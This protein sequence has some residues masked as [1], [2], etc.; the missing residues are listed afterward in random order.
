M[1]DANSIDQVFEKV[2]ARITKERI[3]GLCNIYGYNLYPALAREASMRDDRKILSVED[4]RPSLEEVLGKD[5]VTT[6]ELGCEMVQPDDTFSLIRSSAGW[7]R[8]KSSRYF[9]REDVY[10]WKPEEIALFVA[11]AGH[12]REWCGEKWDSY[13]AEIEEQQRVDRIRSKYR[14]EKNKVLEQ[15][16]SYLLV[17][18][19]KKV[20]LED[21]FASLEHVVFKHQEYSPDEL[22]SKYREILEREDEEVGSREKQSLQD[23]IV[24]M[25]AEAEKKAQED[26][27]RE[28]RSARAREQYAERKAAQKQK[29]EDAIRQLTERLGIAPTITR[30]YPPYGSH[31]DDYGFPLSNGQTISFKDYKKD[32]DW[33]AVVAEKMLPLFEGLTPFATSKFAVKGNLT[34]ATQG[35]VEYR[36]K[37]VLEE[38]PSNSPLLLV[39][40]SLLDECKTL[41][42][43]VK[44][45]VIEV[46]YYFNRGGDQAFLFS[47]PKTFGV[48]DA[49]SFG[50]ALSSFIAADKILRRRLLE[51]GFDKPLKPER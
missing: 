30:R 4:C 15:Y 13:F 36:K 47:I 12:F 21:P 33:I 39:V 46:Q 41:M 17:E 49:M 9:W 42:F 27:R 48:K 10:Q 23:R 3:V 14:N 8:M 50:Y 5:A 51:Y 2:W 29:N 44:P 38:L 1:L 45:R 26:L 6:T 20:G 25:K 37:R 31:Y 32:A 16:A 22:E 7:L 28:Q 43:E 35:M 19:R 34:R 11:R 18:A 40:T 24:Q